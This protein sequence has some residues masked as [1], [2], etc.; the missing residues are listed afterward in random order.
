M[1]KGNLLS[2][3]GFKQLSGSAEKHAGFEESGYASIDG[4]GTFGAVKVA[5]KGLQKLAGKIRDYRAGANRLAE[6][7]LRG[8]D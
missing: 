1:R 2:Q 8:L 7:W 6:S 5:G 3:A 4:G